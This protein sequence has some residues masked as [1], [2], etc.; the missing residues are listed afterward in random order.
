VKYVLITPAHN[1][2]RF[3]TKTLESMAAQTLLPERWIIVN[4]GSTDKTADIA[5]DFARRF[6]WIELVHRSPRLDRHF[7]A[8]VHAFNAGLERVGSTDFDVIGNLDA[9]ISFDPDYLEFLMKKFA[10]DPTLGVAG[11]PFLE[12]GYDS[13]R[14]S[15]EGENHVPGGCQLFRRRCF[16]D[17]GGYVPNP[18]GGI[19]WIAVTTARMKGWRTR[20]FPERRFHHYRPLGTAGKSGMAASFSYGEKDYYLGGSPLWQLFRVVYRTTKRPLEGLALFV[21]Y[22]WAAIRRAKRP[23]TRDLMRF[24][25]REQMNKLKLIFHR[26]LRFKKID[27]FS[28]VTERQQ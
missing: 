15:F 22:C 17:V 19:D 21:G 2:E 24:H 8:K 6:P 25:R 12:N 5:A 3:I 4:D 9:D 1:E 27:N 13:A 18:A 7:G 26:L 14:D 11:T 28:L 10:T 23:V 16:Q 20:S